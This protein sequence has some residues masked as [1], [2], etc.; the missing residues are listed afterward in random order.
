MNLHL[1]KC[2]LMMIFTKIVNDLSGGKEIFLLFF[3]FMKV[4]QGRKKM[5]LLSNVYKTSYL[6]VIHKKNKNITNLYYY[7]FLT[8]SLLAFHY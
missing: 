1:T 3:V 2:T 5:M 7:Q 6:H 4:Y 8:F